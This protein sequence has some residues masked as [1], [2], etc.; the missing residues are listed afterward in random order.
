MRDGYG[1]RWTVVPV[2]SP[3][4]GDVERGPAVDV[5]PPR[6]ALAL[7]ASDQEWSARSLESVLE[8]NGY[9]VLRAFDSRQA[10]ESARTARPDLIIVD[11]ELPGLGGIGVCRAL[12]E[13]ANVRATTPVL[14][15][16]TETTGRADRIASYRAGAWEV[17]RFPVDAEELT[18]RLRALLQAKFAADRVRQM[19]LVDEMT[20]LYNLRGMLRR[21]RE[22]A[23]DAYRRRRALACVA[24]GPATTDGHPQE[25]AAEWDRTTSVSRLARIFDGARRAADVL[26]RIGPN[27]LL[28]VAPATNAA[29]AVGLARRYTFVLTR[30]R[31]HDDAAGLPG[32]LRAGYYAVS[33]F[34]E[35]ALEPLDLLV[36]ATIALRRA[37]SHGDDEHWAF[38]FNE[39]RSSD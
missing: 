8:P 34:R 29:G 14:I 18:L 31:H 17:L 27:E 33:D 26:G 37:Q 21:T 5:R 7:I 28:V 24:L 4:E 13:D 39:V 35:A 20:G 32:A 9:V 16:A 38:D 30:A 12:H 11:L 3:S 6:P 22:L 23:A 1:V 25:P 10:I 2:S 36:R 19:N 15:T